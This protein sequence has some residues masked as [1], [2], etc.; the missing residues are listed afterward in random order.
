MSDLKK[1]QEKSRKKCF[2]NLNLKELYEK[3]QIDLTVKRK[4][5]KREIEAENN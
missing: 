5:F 4:R 2:Q 1:N 3:S